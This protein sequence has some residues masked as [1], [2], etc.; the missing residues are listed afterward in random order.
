MSYTREDV[1]KRLNEIIMRRDTLNGKYDDAL[2]ACW[3]NRTD[4]GAERRVIYAAY[5]R[6]SEEYVSW[7]KALSDIDDGVDPT[8][9]VL[10]RGMQ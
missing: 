7:C 1:A 4:N 5:V 3:R 10:M 8:L 9:A 6:A 2:R